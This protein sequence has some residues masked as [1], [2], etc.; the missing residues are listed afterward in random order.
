MTPSACRRTAVPA[1]AR[2]PRRQPVPRREPRHR[3]A[4]RV[5]RPGARAGV[6]GG[7]A[8]GRGRSQRTF[9]ACVLPA[10][11]RHRQTDRLQRRAHAR[12]RQFLD[13]P[14]HRDPARPD[15]LQLRRVVPGR[16]NRRRAPV[17]DAERAQ[18]RGSRTADAG[19]PAEVLA[20]LPPEAAALV[21]TLRD[22]SSSAT[23]IRA[24]ISIRRSDRRS[25]RSGSA[26]R[27]AHRT[28]P[29]CIARCSRMR[30]ISI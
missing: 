5:R 7:A 10:R 28:I 14:G 16:G 11:R 19:L 4:L 27:A 18:A 6:V 8:D 15:D 1:P 30:R 23:S 2:T 24:T 20:K 29:P 17:A 12:R 3:H 21:R 9:A 13:A 22:R 26:C 25:S